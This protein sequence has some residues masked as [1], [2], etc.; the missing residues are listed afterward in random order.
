MIERH[1]AVRNSRRAQLGGLVAAM[2]A[3]GSCGWPGK[4]VNLQFDS[5][6]GQPGNYVFVIGPR[7][8]SVVLPALSASCV[9]ISNFA[10]V[11]GR[12]LD[13]QAP[14]T[15]HV[16][17]SKDGVEVMNGGARLDDYATGDVCGGPCTQAQFSMAVPPELVRPFWGPCDQSKLAGTYLIDESNHTGGCVSL[18][19]SQTVVLANGLTQMGDPTCQSDLTAWSSDTCKLQS[20]TTCT[21]ALL[22]VTWN[23]NLT[24]VIG[25]GSRLLGYGDVSMSTPVSCQGEAVLELIRQ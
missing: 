19:T 13:S 4:S 15:L 1:R 16:T 21:S 9:N 18:F 17:V 6:I 14:R 7:S 20:A 3:A 8:C 22:G 11:G 25:D 2:I 24:D 23:L 5:P 10:A 12:W